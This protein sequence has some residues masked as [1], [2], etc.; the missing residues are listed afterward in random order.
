[1]ETRRQRWCGLDLAGTVVIGNDG[2]GDFR[3]NDRSIAVWV[4]Q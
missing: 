1:M 4:Q 2:F 3:C